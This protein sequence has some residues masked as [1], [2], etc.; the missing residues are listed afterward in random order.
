MSEVDMAEPIEGIAIVGMAGRFPQA[1]DLAAFWQNLCA[2]VEATT[3][4]TDDELEA[5]GVPAAQ[6]SQPTYVRS[7]AILEEPAMFDAAFFGLSPREA[8]V[9]DPQH[10]IFLESAWEALEDA[11]YDP[12]AF[13]GA[14]GVYAGSSMNTYLLDNLASNPDILAIIGEYQAMLGNDKDF[15]P[16]RVSYKLNLTGPSVNVQTACSTSLVAVAMACQSLLSFQCD[17]ALAGGVSVMFP[18]HKGYVYREGGILSPDGH[19]RTFDQD[20]QGMY[21]GQGVGIVVLRRLEDALADGDHIYAVIRG[22]AINNDGA[23]KVGYTAPSVDGQA[24]VIGMAQALAEVEP[25]SIGYVEAHGTATP[26]GD[27]IEIAGLSKAF[28]A[29]TD[30]TGFCAIGSVKTNIGHLDAAAGVAGLIK[31]ALALKHRQ[32]PPS[33]NYTAPNPKIDF[34]SSPFYVN[35]ALAEWPT[36]ETPRRAGVSSFG[37]G[38]TNAHVVLEEAPVVEGEAGGERPFHL[39]PLSARSET[40]LQAATERLAAHLAAH[41]E[42]PLADV[43]YTL[44]VGR[45]AFAQRRIVAAR[46]HADAVTALRGLTAGRVFDGRS[47]A[48]EAPPVVFMFSGQGSQYVGMGRGL[49][50]HE[51]VFRAEV[52]RCA[53]FLKPHLGLDLREVMWAAADAA[54]GVADKRM[55]GAAA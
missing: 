39:L 32:I 40:A 17:M 11:G 28:R 41:P 54:D 31:T 38:G 45:R 27:P 42:Q 46:D 19:C 33:L 30:A 24:E 9:I 4:F 1:K 2:G 16:T 18:Q 52:D 47:E 44:Q 23:L 34:E 51:P 8:E 7:K 22:S 26:L 6:F 29:E 53:E 35:T 3:T 50:E 21:P 43:A 37:I 36:G 48:T 25:E 10:R 15:L 12:E 20:A 55:A 49:Y 13:D 5:A 14:I